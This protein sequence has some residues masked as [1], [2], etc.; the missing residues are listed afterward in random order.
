MKP[1]LSMRNRRGTGNLQDRGLLEDGRRVNF[2]Y[3]IFLDLIGKK[4]LVTGTGHDL[5]AKIRSLLDAGARVVYVNPSAEPAIADL[6]SASLIDWQSRGFEAQDL[7]GCL[8]VITD[9]HDNSEV[10]RLAEQQN[11]LCNAVDDPEHC[12]FAFGSVHRQGDLT[13]AVSTNGWAPALAVRLREQIEREIGPEYAALLAI[14]KE[15]RPEITSRIADFDARRDLWYRIVD[16][17]VLDVLRAGQLDSARQKIRNMIEHAVSSISR[18][19]TCGEGAD[20]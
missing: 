20:R 9:Q 3:P 14:L 18:S 4:C 5:A 1:K 15:I 13:I 8:L 16:S 10:F 7:A 17:D 2:R 12:R 6:A 11:I 19:D